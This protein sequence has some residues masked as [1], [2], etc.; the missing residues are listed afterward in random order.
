AEQVVGIL[1]ETGLDPSRLQLET[2][3][4]VLLEHNDTIGAVI[5]AL[6]Q[7]GVRIVLGDFGTGYSSLSYLRRHAIDKLKIDR[8]FVRLLDEDESA[9]AIAKTLIE[10]A[11][12]LKVEV[13]AEGVETDAQKALLV[14][15]GCH[16]MQGYLLSPPLEPGQLLALPGVSSAGQERSVARA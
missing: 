9:R 7:S 3:E 2:T 6:R 13:T 5:A 16:Q 14:G 11:L 1:K 8:S 12:A 10:L 15:M 4:S